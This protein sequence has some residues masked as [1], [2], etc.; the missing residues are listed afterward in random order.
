MKQRENKS[1][2][3]TNYNCWRVVSSPEDSAQLTKF[4][5]NRLVYPHVADVKTGFLKTGFSKPVLT[6]LFYA[7]L[8]SILLIFVPKHSSCFDI[9]F[10][11]LKSILLKF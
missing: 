4:E 3:K 8:N 10:L 2:L 6:N 7:Q 11:S 5:G 9:I 1:L